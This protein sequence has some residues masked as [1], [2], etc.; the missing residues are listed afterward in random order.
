MNARNFTI[1]IDA[2]NAEGG[3]IT[4]LTEMFYAIPSSNY[5]D[6]KF[7]I[8]GKSKFNFVILDFVNI[9]FVSFGWT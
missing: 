6:I 1:G 4:H 9:V 5:R 7:V 8:W 3:A 2:S